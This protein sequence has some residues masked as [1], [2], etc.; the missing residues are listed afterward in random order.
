MAKGPSMF[1]LPS[2][3]PAKRAESGLTDALQNVEGFTEEDEVVILDEKLKERES[4][5]AAEIQEAMRS[6]GDV[7]AREAERIDAAQ[8]RKSDP[9]LT[10]VSDR[11]GVRILMFTSDATI[12]EAES[13]SRKRILEL[14]RMF[15]EIHIVL[16]TMRRRDQQVT[17]RIADNVWIY[18]TNSNSW[19][20]TGLDAYR[21][22]KEQ[23]AFAGGFR[24][25]IVISEDPFEA[26]VAAYYIAEKYQRP[27]QVHVLEDIYDPVFTETD[28]VHWLHE[29][30]SHFTLRRADC[31]RTRSEYLK[32][33]IVH[34]YKD[35]R[36]VTEVLPLYHNL[37][38][39]RDLSPTFNLHERYPQFKFIMLHIS[40]MQAHSYTDRVLNGAAFTLKRYPTVGLVI[41]GSGPMRSALEKQAVNLGIQRQVVFEPAQADVVSHMKTANILIHLSESAEEEDVLLKAAAVKL[42]MIATNSGLAA[43]LFVDG[44]SAFLCP[45][46]DVGCVS[47]RINTFLNE[48]QARSRFALNAQE[49][50]FERIEQDYGVYLAAYKESIERCVAVRAM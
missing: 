28:D 41:V 47:S 24:A 46:G 10:Y 48:N 12:L 26:G 44:E 25:D 49:I 20:R 16:L 5:R 19:W 21:I 32:E 9:V 7:V 43:E 35:L 18:V 27:L 13:L 45:P 14:S 33:H 8:A 36:E 31:V 15:P 3:D 50:V 17:A 37:S 2:L 22:A 40:D 4:A 34:E 6:G 38:T 23:L 1:D 11:D 39:W 30:M 29:L 42:P